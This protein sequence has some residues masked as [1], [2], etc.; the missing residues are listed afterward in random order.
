MFSFISGAYSDA[1]YGFLNSSLSQISRC[2]SISFLLSSFYL[3][4]TSMSTGGSCTLLDFLCLE[5]LDST[6][7]SQFS[8]LFL[9]PKEILFPFPFPFFSPLAFVISFPNS[10]VATLFLIF[11]PIE[12]VMDL[13]ERFVETREVTAMFL[14][15]VEGISRELT[16]PL[17]S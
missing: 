3:L 4:T 10:L 16:I 6:L 15:L 14:T 2:V 13:I 8:L 5:S 11:P 12:F 17:L 1:D 7:S 9:F